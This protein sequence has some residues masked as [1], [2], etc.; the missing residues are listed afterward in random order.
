MEA[1]YSPRGEAQ[2]AARRLS[3]SCLDSGPAGCGRHRGPEASSQGSETERRPRLGGGL[4]CYITAVAGLLPPTAPID[5]RLH[6][7][8]DYGG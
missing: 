6:R 3:A 4:L 2:S 8:W 7:H 5:C 1:R